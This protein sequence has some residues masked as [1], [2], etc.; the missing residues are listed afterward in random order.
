M[1]DLPASWMILNEFLLT[2]HG[3]LDRHAL[4]MPT[5]R[6]DRAG[7]YVALRAATWNA[8]LLIFWA[9]LLRIDQVGVHD[10]FFE[11]GG[12]SLLIV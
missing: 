7:E 9:D 12:H 4:P 2:P 3:K 6:G 11:L 8:R 10:N 5:S 1:K